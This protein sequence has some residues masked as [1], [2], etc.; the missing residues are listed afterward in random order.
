[1]RLLQAN[2][3]SKTRTLLRSFAFLTALLGGVLSAGAV[4]PAAQGSPA[5]DANR[6][7]AVV[8]DEVVTQAELNRALVPAY[9]Q[10]QA[11][12]GPE[13]LA[14]EM[15]NLKQRILEQIVDERLMLQEARHPRPVEVSKGK[16]GTPPVITAS[17][18]EVENLLK[19]S[20]AR[21][22]DEEAFQETLS[23]QGVTLEDLKERFRD[24][25]VIQKLISR[26]VR[27]RVSVSPAE[28]TA[29]YESHKEEFVTPPAAQVATLLIRPK[30]TAD[31]PQAFAR[32]QDLQKQL[33]KGAD[34]YE[35]AKK[36]SDGFN[37][38]MGGRMGY[39]EK[40]KNLK[41]IDG[42][43][44]NLKAGEIS[45]IIK[46][47][48]GFHLFLV[49]SVRPAHQ[50]TLDEVTVDLKYKLL[51]QKGAGRYSQWI[52]KLRAESYITMK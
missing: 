2:L 13:E 9:F 5:D 18:D 33:E 51:S 43:L 16:I 41:E 24:Q 25:A 44:F 47:S 52:A 3:L 39:L 21:F 10:L 32:A 37:A 42:I 20:R 35:T 14:K 12:L 50:A 36:N 30:D 31:V 29:Y 27:S 23:Q 45:P 1:M 15:G 22:P 4:S 46:T 40:G 34:F 6:I 49:E 11:T 28:I 19:E 38:Q 26:E 17:E 7:V 8:N 48:A